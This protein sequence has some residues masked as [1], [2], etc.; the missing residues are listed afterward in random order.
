M[1]NIWFEVDDA[2][3]ETVKQNWLDND[4]QHYDSN[5]Y[6]KPVGSKQLYS[7]WTK[8]S[9]ATALAVDVNAAALGAWD[10]ATGAPDGTVTQSGDLLDYMPDLWNG[11]DPPT[12]SPPTEVTDRILLSGQAPRVF[13]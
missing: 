3:A 9:V 7:V 4:M 2:D 10:A 5:K 8:D 12:Y 13:T 11:D 6:F 1:N